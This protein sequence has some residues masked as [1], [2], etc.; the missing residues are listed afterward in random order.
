MRVHLF[1]LPISLHRRLKESS[2]E[3]EEAVP[4]GHSFR[5]TPVQSNE[6]SAFSD[7]EI[8]EI[9]T[10]VEEGF[11]HIIIPANRSW[12][13]INRRFQFD[14]RIHVARLREPLRD[15]TWP[16][17]KESLHRAV[18]MDE[19]WLDKFCPR[20]LRHPL[21]LPPTVFEP[22]KDTTGYWA[23]CDVYRT[24]RFEWAERLLSEVEKRHRLPDGEGKRTWVDAR[25]RR[26]RFD[27]SKHGRSGTNRAGKK[28]FRFCFEVPIG[29]HYDVATDKDGY[30]T[31]MINGK[32]ES[33]R[34]CNA[35]PWG[36]VWRGKEA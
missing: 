26:F 15:L 36:R 23:Q 7:T 27:P 33:V 14:C 20:D 6:M 30:F 32:L 2:R 34:H 10:A 13:E 19:I 22:E 28:A 29:F 35:N 9:E 5:A 24:D 16:M 31:V 25:G 1:G 12:A 4:V 21:L 17:L 8:R 18:E 3:W 11:T